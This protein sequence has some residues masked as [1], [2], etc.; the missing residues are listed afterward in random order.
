MN[1]HILVVDDD[2]AIR[3]AIS[4]ALNRTGFRVTEAPN[5]EEALDL[6]RQRHGTEESYDL[7]LTDLEMPRMTGAELISTLQQENI[8]MPTFVISANWDL[9][10]IDAL[11]D[12]GCL[13]FIKKPFELEKLVHRI[14]RALTENE[15]GNQS[16]PGI[17]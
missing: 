11:I 1:P 14:D 13:D 10:V 6:I 5:G 7:L 15:N 4:F 8:P 3:S 16:P 2:R 9:D 17:A 12:Q